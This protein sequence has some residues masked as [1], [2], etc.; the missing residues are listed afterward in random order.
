MSTLQIA[1]TVIGPVVV[2][3]IVVALLLAARPD[4]G[5]GGDGLYAAY[6][7]LAS[8]T[9][10][11]WLLLGGVALGESITRQIVVGDLTLPSAD[12]FLELGSVAGLGGE[13]TGGAVAS[14]AAVV[15]VAAIAFGFHARRRHELASGDGFAG[16]AAERV[17]RAYQAGV[18]FTMIPIGILAALSAGGAGYYFLS[19][20][21]GNDKA[22][23]LAGGLLLSYGALLLVAFVI[24]Q[25]HFWAMRSGTGRASA[26]EPEL[27]DLDDV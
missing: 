13:G 9:A 12:L 15:V 3:L 18:C 11:Y 1:S 6:L 27:A 21:N 5:P 17:D 20:P 22:R 25:F 2:V 8:V 23:D 16:S 14:Y 10:L 24:F 7:S 26:A 19:D 4:H